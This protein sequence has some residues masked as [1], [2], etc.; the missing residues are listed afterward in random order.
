MATTLFEIGE[1]LD[2]QERLA[3]EATGFPKLFDGFSIEDAFDRPDIPD[4]EPI[5]PDEREL[6]A[7]S[8][9]VRDVLD[10]MLPFVDFWYC[11]PFGA[12]S[13]DD[14]DE[15][16]ECGIVVRGIGTAVADIRSPNV[17]A[18]LAMS[19]RDSAI[20][21]VALADKIDALATG[22]GA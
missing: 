18:E 9:W 17:F 20:G 10:A 22:G 3:R 13:T 6:A 21:C 7:K 8:N 11:P 14:D 1:T 12:G 2:A 19:L 5:T 15:R 4:D 16:F